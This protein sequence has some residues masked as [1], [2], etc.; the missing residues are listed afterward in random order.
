MAEKFVMPCRVEEGV[1]ETLFAFAKKHNYV[2]I[3]IRFYGEEYL[4]KNKLCDKT[5]VARHTTI[6]TGE[7]FVR[8]V[9]LNAHLESDLL[10]NFTSEVGDNYVCF[11][12]KRP[13]S[14]GKLSL[15]VFMR[16]YNMAVQELCAAF[17]DYNWCMQE[18]ETG[19]YF[20]EFLQFLTHA[21]EVVA[22]EKLGKPVS[23][24]FLEKDG[25]VILD[26]Y[27]YN[28][29]SMADDFGVAANSFYFSNEGNYEVLFSAVKDVPIWDGDLFLEQKDPTL[30]CIYWSAAYKA[31]KLQEYIDLANDWLK[32]LGLQEG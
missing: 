13:C 9:L 24:D 8:L 20:D 30:R 5:T 26:T 16:W 19:V 23:F 25:K 3:M 4:I 10:G 18:I 32:A 2:P 21:F 1:E 29:A 12:G 11:W 27:A 31:K 7:E 22:K 14:V 15:D 17:E 28:F 6:D